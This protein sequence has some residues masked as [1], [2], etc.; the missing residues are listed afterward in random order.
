LLLFKVL[1]PSLHLQKICKNESL[2]YSQVFLKKKK[3]GLVKPNSKEECCAWCHVLK[4]DLWDMTLDHKVSRTL[5]EHLGS[6][7][8]KLAKDQKVC[9]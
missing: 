6:Y 4:K 1:L 9:E 7:S 2:Y 5:A 8:K 3:I